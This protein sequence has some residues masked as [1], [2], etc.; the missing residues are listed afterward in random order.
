MAIPTW[1]AN[2]APTATA[3]GTTRTPTLPAHAAGDI[4][5]V[6]AIHNS[7]ANLTIAAGWNDVVAPEGNANLSTGLWWKRAASG[8]ETNPLVT[9]SVAADASNV[10]VADSFNIRGCNTQGDPFEF[11]TTSGSPTSSTAITSQAI[12]TIKPDRL[13]VCFM[14]VDKN[15][16]H[17][18]LPGGWTNREDVTTATA[19]TAAIIIHSIGVASPATTASVTTS[20]LTVAQFW[21][22]FTMA[23]IPASISAPPI[24]KRRG[25][26]Q[27][28]VR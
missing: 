18:G 21:K 2:G 11:A 8:A 9:S 6:A 13:V 19:G 1:Q 28:F 20:T 26:N 23:F 27:L 24:M 14:L 15:Q 16:A 7:A 3:S 5:V 25:L 12:T 4:L 10:L 17:S 22:S